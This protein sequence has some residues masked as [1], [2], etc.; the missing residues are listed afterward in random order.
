MEPFYREI[1]GLVRSGLLQEAYVPA[2][3]P[4]WDRVVTVAEEQN[5][6]A[7]LDRAIRISPLLSVP[8]ETRKKLRVGFLR[9]AQ[10][11]RLEEKELAGL[12]DAF[13]R[14]KIDHLPLKG[15]VMKTYY[16][17]PVCRY[18]GDADIVIRKEQYEQTAGIMKELGYRFTKESDHELRWEKGPFTVELHKAAVD[19]KYGGFRDY[20]HDVFEKAAPQAG[21]HRYRLTPVNELVHAAAHFTKHYILG[22]ARLRSLTDLY[23]LAAEGKA[24][25]AE[26]A[27]VLRE[28]HLDTFY[29]VALD[30]A[31]AWLGGKEIGDRGALL[32]EGILSSS[33]EGD[34][35][36]SMTLH[37]ANRTDAGS[38][39]KNALGRIFIPYDVMR[40]RF[41][42]L[43]KAPFL[44][45]VLWLWRIVEVPLFRR[46]RLRQFMDVQLHREETVSDYMDEMKQLGLTDAVIPG[47]L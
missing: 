19:P 31:K 47:G 1:L 39:A 13:E 24:D 6:Y 15:T 32:L 7:L 18:M 3:E 29:G 40:R 38:A 10:L 2:E 42:V 22:G 41:P 9:E 12:F 11:Q 27:G 44:L 25:E 8:E 46:K 14:G 37:A 35:T 5:L 30:T 4:D 34:F 26:L 33:K 21:T 16:P 17:S 45:P 20:F 43:W 36:R 28:L 23:Y